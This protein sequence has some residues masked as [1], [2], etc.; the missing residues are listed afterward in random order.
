[1]GYLYIDSD[2]TLMEPNHQDWKVLGRSVQLPIASQIRIKGD[3]LQ[4]R[5]DNLPAY[6]GIAPWIGDRALWKDVLNSVVGDMLGGQKRRLGRFLFACRIDQ[7]RGQLSRVVADAVPEGANRQTTFHVLCGLAGGTGSGTV[8]DVIA[9]IRDRFPDPTEHRILVYALLPEQHPNPTWAKQ[10]YHPNGFAALIELNGL[11]VGA[12]H[13]RDLAGQKGRLESNKTDFN[14]CY[15][16]SNENTNGIQVSVENSIPQIIADFLFQKIIV[17]RTTIWAGLNRMENAEN[18]DGLP[19][20]PAG[21][22]ERS[23]RFLS[24]G[25]KRIVIPEQE[26]TEFLTYTFARQTLRQLA[27]NHWTDSYGFID[28]P[29]PFDAAS[30]VQQPACEERWLLSD[31]HILQEVASLSTDDPQRR[32]KLFSDDWRELR[33]RRCP[34]FAPAI[35]SSGSPKRRACSAPALIGPLGTLGYRHFS[36]RASNLG[37]ILRITFEASLNTNSSKS[38]LRA[39]ARFSKSDR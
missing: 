27:A 21:N 13:P 8:L 16:I 37:V 31:Q 29:L 7:F 34:A 19:E 6:P 24:F 9:Q 17:S 32:W 4:G 5:L 38:G 36:A 25:I 30:Y 35:K 39:G 14:G 33:R 26:I 10:N 18:G 3:S 2:Y 23:K 12:Y 15:L 22:P 28:E 11:S 20:S 1:L